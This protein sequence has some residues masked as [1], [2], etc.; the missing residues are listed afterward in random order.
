MKLRLLNSFLI[1]LALTFIP[2]IAMAQICTV[3]QGNPDGPYR[4]GTFSQVDKAQSFKPTASQIA[5]A[6]AFVHDSN[7]GSGSA[8]IELWTA[9]PNVGGAT[10]LAE[11]TGTFSAVNQWVDV[12]WTPVAVTPGTTY[13]LVLHGLPNGQLAFGGTLSNGYADGIQYTNAGFQPYQSYDFAFR[14]CTEFVLPPT[15]VAIPTLSFWAI[16]TLAGLM[17]LVAQYYR[18]RR[19]VEKDC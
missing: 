12:E 14:T 13:Y 16:L 17:P 11:G 5:G 19:K 6:S 15:P 9:L 4:N 8:T 10:K 3:D 7:S 2:S 1:I 18:R